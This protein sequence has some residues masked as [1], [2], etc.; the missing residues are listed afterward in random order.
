MWRLPLTLLASKV[1]A[2]PLRVK[3]KLPTRAFVMSPGESSS[4]SW[5]RAFTVN[6]FFR[7]TVAGLVDA[8]RTTARSRSTVS[9][10]E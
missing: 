4:W 3:V 9:W 2:W 6:D 10:K 5:T 1:R 7:D 8:I